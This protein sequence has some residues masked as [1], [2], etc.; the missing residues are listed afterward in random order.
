MR[1]LSLGVGPSF[2]IVS[3]QRPLVVVL[4]NLSFRCAAKRP[5]PARSCADKLIVISQRLME[6]ML[7]VIDNKYRHDTIANSP[8]TV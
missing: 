6:K 5:V 1:I 7:L 4:W 2:V 3:F 8:T